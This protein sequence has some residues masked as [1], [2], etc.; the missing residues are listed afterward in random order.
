MKKFTPARI[1]RE[2]DEAIEIRVNPGVI[3]RIDQE[4]RKAGEPSDLEGRQEMR[5]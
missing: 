4:C 5:A 1:H 2:P 3:K